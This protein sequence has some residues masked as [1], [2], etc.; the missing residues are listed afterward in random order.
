M[1]LRKKFGLMRILAFLPIALS[2]LSS[3]TEKDNTA[4]KEEQ[5]CDIANLPRNVIEFGFIDT[6]NVF[7]PAPLVI[8]ES[9]VTIRDLE[10]MVNN[11]EGFTLRMTLRKIEF[12]DEEKEK[13]AL[14]N[15]FGESD[16]PGIWTKFHFIDEYCYNLRL[17]ISSTVPFFLKEETDS[18]Y[19]LV[20]RLFKDGRFIMRSFVF[21][22]Y[23][24]LKKLNHIYRTNPE[25]Q[26]NPT[27]GFTFAL[28]A[29]RTGHFWLQRFIAA[30]DLPDPC[31][32]NILIGDIIETVIDVQFN[33]YKNPFNSPTM[34]KI[35]E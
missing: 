31:N 20:T 34:G 5:I 28:P 1:I 15:M 35:K 16:L 14:R 8:H 29:S 6:N 3:C 22:D 30:N 11:G 32:R 2:A 24:Y 19:V 7:T 33:E 21:V 18:N 12:D 27:G 25:Y 13:C 17:N 23:E 10:N 4:K 9:P 26:E